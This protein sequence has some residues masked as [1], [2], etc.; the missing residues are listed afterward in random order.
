MVE[1]IAEFCQNHNGDFE[2]LKDMVHAAKESGAT[3]GKI[4]TIFSKDLTNRPR[5]E[6][7]LVKENKVISIKRPFYNEYERLKKL[8]LSYAQ[9]QEFIEVCKRAGLKPITTAFTIKSVK[10]LSQIGFKEIKV[11]S[12]DCSS[13]PL[14]EEIKQY[15]NRIIISTGA[16]YDD[17][18]DKAYEI[19]KNHNFDFLHCVT[20]YPTPL[21]K[22]HLSRMEYLKKYT[23]SVGFSEHSLVQ[24]DGL[25]ASKVALWMKLI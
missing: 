19:L 11:A 5:F 14:L 10:K 21:E 3:H 1:I 7:G 16:T 2:I 4:Q 18:I 17:E 12:Y 20:I 9:Q 8:D 13:Y 23:K 6:N 22:M 25:K 15:F 24:K